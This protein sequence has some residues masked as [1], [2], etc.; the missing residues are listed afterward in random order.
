V[1]VGQARKRDA[2]EPAIV[3]ALEQIG[4]TVH[5]LSAPGLP[6]L[7]AH[8]WRE[9]LVLLEVKAEAGKLT[10]LQLKTKCASLPFCVVRSVAEALA[11]FGVKA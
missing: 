3:D 4:V 7:L 6:D 9:G 10:P 8:H 5:R 11:I 2:N 1:R